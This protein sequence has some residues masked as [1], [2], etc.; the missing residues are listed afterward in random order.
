M[1][2]C[3]IRQIERMDEMKGFTKKQLEAS[4]P[5]VPPRQVIE[6]CLHW[7]Y[8]DKDHFVTD[9]LAANTL[10]YEEVI[11]ALLVGLDAAIANEE[12]AG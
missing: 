5:D 9:V 11:G 8:K 7:L 1:A 4:R 6:S 10:S 12:R 3:R 2:G